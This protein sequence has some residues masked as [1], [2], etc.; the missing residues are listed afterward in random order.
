MSRLLV[1][2]TLVLLASLAPDASAQILVGRAVVGAHTEGTVVATADAVTT[3]I[4]RA[5]I[6][7][8]DG[9]LLH[10]DADSS[11]RWEAAGPLALDNGR[12][13]LRTG[14]GGWLDVV[15]PFAR[16]T[17]A[18]AGAYGL[19][20]DASHARLLVTVMAGGADLQT[21][22][23]QATLG[24]SEMVVLTESTSRLVVT[25]FEPTPWDMFM[26]W[27]R[28]R[29]SARVLAARQADLQVPGATVIPLGPGGFQESGPVA[30]PAP[31]Y[32]GGEGS[33]YGGSGYDGWPV[34]GYG[35]GR[36][37]S[38]KRR[39]PYAPHYEPHYEP[40]GG[41]RGTRSE[42]RGGPGRIGPGRGAPT[43]PEL[44]PAI[45]PAPVQTPP[46]ARGG[47]GKLPAPGLPPAG[48]RPPG[49]SARQYR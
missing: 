29:L 14:T 45:P 26:L 25:A 38:D 28:A 20:V 43:P 21:S 32:S 42:G 31:S 30:A 17:L 22:A 40:Y 15:L 44:P 24:P 36:D 23:A 10:V 2:L 11:V 13:L 41:S 33:W 4:G 47:V 34:W 49:G 16:V 6:L 19:L 12:V 27:S 37:W 3:S 18:P 7:F 8:A 35:G 39:D 46:P 48:A 1:A 5:E 9:T